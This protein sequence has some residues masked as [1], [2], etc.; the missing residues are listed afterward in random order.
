MRGVLRLREGARLTA[1]MQILITFAL[2]TFSMVFFKAG[3]FT[4]AIS[5]LSGMV[6]G[7][8]WAFQSM[9]LDKR[10]LL[11]AAAGMLILLVVDILSTKRD[12]TADFLGAK[13]VVRW[14]GRSRLSP[15]PTG[16]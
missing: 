16:I 6:R 10:E 14:A 12:L 9:G 1:L 5:V 15:S 13:Q 11:A 8:L 7:P 2:F 4:Q 3:S